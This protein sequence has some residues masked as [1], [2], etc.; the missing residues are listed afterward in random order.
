M[1][2][3]QTEDLET[4]LGLHNQ[5]AELQQESD[6]LQ[7]QLDDLQAKP[8]VMATP[9]K[10]FCKDPS[11]CPLYVPDIVPGISTA[12]INRW[13]DHTCQSLGYLILRARGL[14]IGVRLDSQ[15]PLVWLVRMALGQRHSC[16]GLLFPSPLD[17]R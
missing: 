17:V 13:S 2:R 14:V 12:A 1:I 8:L 5:M 16:I 15:C 6:R 4:T 3:Q 7:Q 9:P 10:I 11:V